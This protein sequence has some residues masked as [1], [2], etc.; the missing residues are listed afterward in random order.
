MMQPPNNNKGTPGNN[1]R[2]NK[3]FADAIR[4]IERRIDGKLSKDQI[5]RLHDA[6]SGQIYD[7]HDIVEEGVRMFGN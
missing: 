5:R 4:E 6:I 3:Q 7:Y 2:Q 1:Q